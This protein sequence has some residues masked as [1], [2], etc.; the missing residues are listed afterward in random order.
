MCFTECGM[1]ISYT[2]LPRA[3][4]LLGLHHM[5]LRRP[6]CKESTDNVEATGAWS[7]QKPLPLTPTQLLQRLRKPWGTSFVQRANLEGLC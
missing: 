6:L 1:V 4:K 2:K 3:L 7:L 5:A